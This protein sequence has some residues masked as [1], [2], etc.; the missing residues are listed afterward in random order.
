MGRDKQSATFPKSER[1]SWKRH[2][3]RLFAEGASFIS[4]PLRIVY[5]PVKKEF[6]VAAVSVLVSVPKRKIKH[7][8]DRNFIKRRMRESY[9]LRKQDLL[10][11]FTEKDEALLIAFLYLKEEKSSFDVIDR[12]MEK[13]F[14]SLRSVLNV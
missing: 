8:V 14:H 7:A 5:L 13:A 1:L 2:V 12:A 4:Y 6:A 11:L 9:R 3:D 10:R